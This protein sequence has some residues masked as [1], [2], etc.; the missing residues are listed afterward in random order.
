MMTWMSVCASHLGR[1]TGRPNDKPLLLSSH[2]ADFPL[3]QRID[4]LGILPN[5][6]SIVRPVQLLVSLN[7]RLSVGLG[8]HSG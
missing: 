7:P 6:F 2:T 8:I 5:L 1:E 4:K 3:N